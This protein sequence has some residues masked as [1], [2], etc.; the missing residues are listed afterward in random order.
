[1]GERLVVDPHDN[2]ILFFGTRSGN[3]LWKS[4]DL[5]R[6][7]YKYDSVLTQEFILGRRR[8]VMAFEQLTS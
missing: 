3:G 2:S 7:S 4:T 6:L 5:Y 1:M 8:P